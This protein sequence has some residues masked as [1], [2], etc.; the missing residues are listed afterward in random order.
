M[1]RGI[2]FNGASLA[3]ID[4]YISDIH[5]V[6]QDTQAIAGWNGPGSF[7]IVNNELEAAGENVMFGGARPALINNIPRIS[8]LRESFSSPGWM[9]R[10]LCRRSLDGQELLEFKSAQVLITGNLKQLGGRST[11]S[12]SDLRGLKMGP[13][14]V[15]VH[16]TF[17]ITSATRQAGQHLGLDS[18]DPR[19]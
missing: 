16:I 10:P 14:V 18:A 8:K 2:A 9:V 5:V 12:L 1:K 11:D 13:L 3:I 17:P 6:G 15:Y 4:S 19:N 7:K